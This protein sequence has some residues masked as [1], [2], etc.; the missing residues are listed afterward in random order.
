MSDAILD[1]GLSYEMTDDGGSA[2][3]MAKSQ[4]NSRR[5]SSIRMPDIKMRRWVATL[6]IS[7]PSQHPSGRHKSSSDAYGQ[8]FDSLALKQ[9]PTHVA[10][11]SASSQNRRDMTV[12]KLGLGAT[13]ER[14]RIPTCLTACRWPHTAPPCTATART[15]SPSRMTSPNCRAACGDR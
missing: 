2:I 15:G 11:M 8:A 1:G 14:R 12:S 4:I 6:A 7:A 13:H 5:V 10:R 9:G 3:W